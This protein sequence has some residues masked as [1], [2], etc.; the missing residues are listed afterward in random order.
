MVHCRGLPNRCTNTSDKKIPVNMSEYFHV[1][2]AVAGRGPGNPGGL[3][4]PVVYFTVAAFT[5]ASLLFLGHAVPEFQELLGDHSLALMLG[6]LLVNIEY[7]YHLHRRTRRSAQAAVQANEALQK[8]AHERQRAQAELEET[9]GQL[10]ETARRAGMAE[11]AAEAV[12]NIGTALNTAGVSVGVLTE[13]LTES[14]TSQLTRVV[15]LMR[16][17]EDE[18]GFFLTN[19]DR[20]KHLLDYLSKLNELVAR[21]QT[22]SLEELAQLAKSIDHI[23]AI[24]RKQ[25]CDAPFGGA[26]EPVVLAELV[27]D[28]L[29]LSAPA[30]SCGGIRVVRELNGT[31]PVLVDRHKLL[32][33]LVNLIRNAQEALRFTKRHGDRT[34]TV[35]VREAADR[36][37]RIQIADNGAGISSGDLPRIF[38]HGFTAKK[39]GHGFGLHN[40]AL[41]AQEMGGSVTA[42]SDGPHKG[43]TFTVDLPLKTAEVTC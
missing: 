6:A 39:N 23:E 29:R 11:V 4:L 33:I 22:S 8:E 9:Q 24:V 7:L 40:A 16:R 38:A 12:H 18:L 42:Q 36:S 28:A 3:G 13:Q 43:A 30:P 1:R 5:G 14:K 17:H 27:E 34:L 25:Q 26:E 21:E 31:A 20:G 2:R 19:D 10:L 15:E 35:R 32:Q 37:I 41:E